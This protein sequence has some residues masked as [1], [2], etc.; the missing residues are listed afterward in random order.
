[1]QKWKMFW[2]AKCAD[3]GWQTEVAHSGDA[4]PDLESLIAAAT[5]LDDHLVTVHDYS[6]ASAT[7]VVRRWL[8]SSLDEIERAERV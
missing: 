2:V 7:E 4:R 5:R 1:M 8:R 6:F 3:C